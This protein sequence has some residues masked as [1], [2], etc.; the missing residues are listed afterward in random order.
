MGEG[1][2]V[3]GLED[4]LN[5]LLEQVAVSRLVQQRRPEGFHLA[6]MVA[7]AHAED[8]PTLGEDVGGGE[9]FGQPQRI[10]HRRDVEAATELQVLGQVGQMDIEHQEV[11]DALVT[12]GLEVVLG[13]PH[14]VVT[15][16]VHGLGYGR[17]LVEGGGQILV[18]VRAVVHCGAAV[19]D[20]VHIH[21]AGVK[22]VELA[23]HVA[24]PVGLR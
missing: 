6:G 12:L 2:F 7:P 14:S 22:A 21:V 8:D 17:G 5:L 13:H 11:G 1:P 4:N 23:N 16:A 3:K 18:G 9:V 10:P 20:V 24:P 15:Q 19:T